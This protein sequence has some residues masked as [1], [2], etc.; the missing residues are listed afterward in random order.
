MTAKLTVAV[1]ASGRGSNLEALLKACAAPDF[2]AR[3]GLVICNVAGAGALDKAK[4]FGVTALT[5]DHRT[6]ATRSAFDA[7]LDSALRDAGVDLVCLAGF[8]RLLTPGFTE[9]WRGRLINIHPSLLPSFKGLSTHRRALEA[10]VK[11]H[12]CSVHFVTADLDDGPIIA[13]AAVV[14]AEQDD[15]TTLAAKVLEAEHRLYPLALRLIGEGAVT[16]DNGR[17]KIARIGPTD[18]ML[19]SAD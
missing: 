9:S 1:L 13:Q 5:I 17:V 6:F 10:G 8:M 18:G 12:G 4:H 2:P 16:I 7:A 15:E 19:L 14:V 3:I 11:L